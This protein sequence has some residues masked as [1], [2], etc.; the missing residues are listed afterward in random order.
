M[1][2]HMDLFSSHPGHQGIGFFFF[3]R[4]SNVNPIHEFDT[5][6]HKMRYLSMFSLNG[7]SISVDWRFL[8]VWITGQCPL[9]RAGTCSHADQTPPTVSVSLP[10]L[11]SIINLNNLVSNPAI[12]VDVQTLYYITKSCHSVF[13]N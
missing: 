3:F 5:M 12:R 8:G 1:N 10:A 4:N 7:T 6:K 13:E 2:H 9:D 11:E